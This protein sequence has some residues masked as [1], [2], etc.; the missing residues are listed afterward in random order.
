M[1]MKTLY[2]AWESKPP[3]PAWYPV[4]R[5]DADVEK[6]EYRFRYTCGAKRAQ[7]LAGFPL[8]MEF[9]YLNE[10]YTASKMFPLFHNRV[11]NAKRPDFAAHLINLGLTEDANPVEILAIN[12]GRRVTDA[13]EVFPKIEN[14]ANGK[15]TCRFFLHGWRYVNKSSVER[16]KQIK[17]GDQLH[18]TLEVANPATKHAVQ[19]QTKDYYMIGWVPRYLVHDLFAALKD[20]QKYSA[21]VVRV[22]SINLPTAPPV[23]HNLRVLIELESQWQNQNHNPMG[24]EDYQPLVC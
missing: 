7:D 2:L 17:E 12:G 23:P 5:L 21:R 16:I 3:R 4:G 11:M 10:D 9:P 1:S 24:S 15:F 22:N 13:Y 8:L 18:L 14:T 20:D 6:S 19:I